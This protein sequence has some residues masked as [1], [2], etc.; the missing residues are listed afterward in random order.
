MRRAKKNPHTKYNG[1]EECS[2]ENYNKR[3]LNRAL[4]C[5]NEEWGTDPCFFEALVAKMVQLQHRKA[6]LLYDILMCS[7]AYFVCGV[8]GD[9]K[10][11]TRSL[12]RMAAAISHVNILRAL[13][14]LLSWHRLTRMFGDPS[15]ASSSSSSSPKS[16]VSSVVSNAFARNMET[17]H[18]YT[19]TQSIYILFKQ[20]CF[21]N[22]VVTINPS[23]SHCYRCF[24]FFFF[25]P[26]SFFF[27]VHAA[28]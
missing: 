11:I 18:T 7:A 22:T 25:T 27:F 6:S 24:F 16:W 8:G 17:P 4:I 12:M 5:H 20:P 28:L 19:R 13:Q 10:N 21:C 14:Q 26:I 1:Q 23:W 3:L 9:C 2:P 15:K